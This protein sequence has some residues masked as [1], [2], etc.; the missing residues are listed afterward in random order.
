VNRRPFVGVSERWGDRLGTDP[1]LS[2]G[3]GFIALLEAFRATG[4]TAPGEVVGRLLE[5]HK[6]GNATSLAKLVYTGQVF[7]FEWRASLWIPMFQ[8]DADDLTLTAGA[9][10]VRAELPSLWPGWTLAC[11]FAAPSAQLGG[12]CPA[13]MIDSDLA[14]VLR[15]A[16]S[17]DSPEGF[18]LGPPRVRGLREAAAHA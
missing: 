15:T 13:D 8:F 6:V 9:Q 17:V 1:G 18:A 16:R 4:G 10:L 7:G 5:E 3:R 12:R 11:W 14:A 2:S